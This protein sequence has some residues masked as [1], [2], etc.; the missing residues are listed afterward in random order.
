[1]FRLRCL[2][3]L[4]FWAL[5]TL[6]QAPSNAIESLGEGKRALAARRGASTVGSRKRKLVCAMSYS[7][8]LYLNDFDDSVYAHHQTKVVNTANIAIIPAGR[9]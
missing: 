3:G 8:V 7:C 1:M 9:T 2:A 5:Q 4:S 6:Q